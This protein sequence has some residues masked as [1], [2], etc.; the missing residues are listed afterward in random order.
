M[1]YHGYEE[2]DNKGQ[3]TRNKIDVHKYLNSGN[4]VALILEDMKNQKNFTVLEM[5]GEELMKPFR[6]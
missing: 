6:P 2:L 5:K 3:K 1:N 4:P